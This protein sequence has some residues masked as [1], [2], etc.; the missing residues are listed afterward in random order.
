MRSRSQLPLL[1]A[2]A[3]LLAALGPTALPSHEA[4]AFAKKSKFGKPK[5]LYRYGEY[6]LKYLPKGPGKGPTSHVPR[7]KIMKIPPKAMSFSGLSGSVE[8]DLDRQLLTFPITTHNTAGLQLRFPRLNGALKISATDPPAS[9]DVDEAAKAVEAN[10]DQIVS[11]V[12]EFGVQLRSNGEWGV[13]FSRQVEDLGFLRTTLNS[14]L[15]WSADLE[16]TYPAVVKGVVPTVNYGATQ[17]GMRVKAKFDRSFADKGVHTSYTMQNVAGKYAP[18]DLMHEARAIASLG[19]GRLTATTSYDR[20]NSKVPVRGSLAYAAKLR[21]A[22]LEASVDF[23]RLRL[24]ASAKGVQVTAAIGTRA[25]LD[26]AKSGIHGRPAELELKV[27][28][29]SASAKL[30]EGKPR[31]R[32]DVGL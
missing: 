3:A 8:S 5:V 14:Q 10:Y 11:G 32:L 23:D 4:L 26:D 25:S 21:A 27:G 9:L 15:D 19:G 2:A 18:A 29:V 17:D 7:L 13:S 24:K 28:K 20:R 16:R 30:R 31:V 1:A 12:G 6:E 22:A